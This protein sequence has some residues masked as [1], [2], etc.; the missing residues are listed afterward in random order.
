[1]WLFLDAV[2]F[3]KVCIFG[4]ASPCLPRGTKKFNRAETEEIKGVDL[5][6]KAER[7]GTAGAAGREAPI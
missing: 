1:M 6:G 2:G 3:S 7:V 4:P 5:R